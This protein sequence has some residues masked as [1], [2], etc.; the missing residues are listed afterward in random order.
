[1]KIYW[2]IA[3]V[4]SVVFVIQTIMTFIGLDGSEG[5]SADFDGGL[6]SDIS[7]G[8]LFSLR[9]LVNFFLGYGWSTVCF[10]NTIQSAAWLNVVSVLVGLVFVAAFFFLMVQITKLAVDKTFKIADTMGKAADVYLAIPGGMQG[11]GKIQV[12]VGG[13]YHE[14][15]AMTR[16]GKLPTGSKARVVEIIDSQ[17][18]LVEQL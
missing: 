6:D 2:G 15:G 10:Y 14:I 11:R 18:V 13:A 16:D 17:T 9:N 12:S 5:M 8:Q 4:A 1:M 7:G 3:L